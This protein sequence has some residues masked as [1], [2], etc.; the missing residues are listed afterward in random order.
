MIGVVDAAMSAFEIISRLLTLD[1]LYLNV[2]EKY[3]KAKLRPQRQS[4]RIERSGVSG[5]GMGVF[6]IGQS[7]SP[8][9][10]KK[11]DRGKPA[12]TQLANKGSKGNLQTDPA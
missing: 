5:L 12:E 8:V 7:T 2:C 3:A 10:M 1:T 4:L 11:R 6:D 9:M